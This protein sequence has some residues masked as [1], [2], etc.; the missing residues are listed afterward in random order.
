MKKK[1]ERCKKSLDKLG[2]VKERDKKGR[3]VKGHKGGPGRHK[4]EPRDI[5]CKDGKKRS[6]EMLITDLLATYKTLGGEKFLK[7]WAASS[8][9]NLARF[10]E[11][12]FK[13]AP[14]PQDADRSSNII[15]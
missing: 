12:L 2:K 13:F 1:Q 10:I 14:Q 9:R 15:Y 6:V 7:K 4:G 5:I 8:N 3:Y 11:I